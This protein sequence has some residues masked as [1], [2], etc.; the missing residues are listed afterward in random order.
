MSRKTL[1]VS[2]SFITVFCIHVAF[3]VWRSSAHANQ[4]L[5]T[6]DE[7]NV[8]RLYFSQQHF[9]MGLSYSLAAA[10]TV[11]AFFSFIANKK[12]GMG[13]VIGSVTLTGFLYFGGCFLVGCCGS[14]MLP[15][16]LGLFGSSFLGFTK[17]IVFGVT[18]VSVILSMMWRNLSIEMRHFF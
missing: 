8:M 14:P 13:G 6:G 7:I 9:F 1:C 5:Q 3:F 12:S 2:I 10:F 15:I 17:P 16:Y 4:W 11:Y 18:L